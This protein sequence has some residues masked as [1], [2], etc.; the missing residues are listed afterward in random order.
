VRYVELI[1]LPGA[2]KSSVA[3]RMAQRHGWVDI[4]E[5]GRRYIASLS[6]QERT[7]HRAMQFFAGEKALRRVWPRFEEFGTFVCDHANAFSTIARVL[8]NLE[9]DVQKVS[10]QLFRTLAE[11][12]SLRRYSSVGETSIHDEGLQQRRVSLAMRGV[13]NHHALSGLSPEHTRIVLIDVP[14]DLATARL[15]R[16]GH[17]RRDTA[18]SG[19]ALDEVLRGLDKPYVTV[20][21]TYRLDRVCDALREALD[22]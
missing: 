14:Q 12:E 3:R 10:G 17:P 8:D 15:Q 16:R 19:A 21:G 20:D 7:F 4:G 6:L 2:G 1:G 13:T 18:V 11:I 5:V 22:S 9:A